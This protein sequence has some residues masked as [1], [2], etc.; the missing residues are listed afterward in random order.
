MLRRPRDMAVTIGLMSWRG[1]PMPQRTASSREL[2]QVSGMPGA[3][4]EEQHVDAAALGDARDLLVDLEVRIDAAGPRAQ[5]APA[6]VEMR[7]GNVERRDESAWALF[8]PHRVSSVVHAPSGMLDQERRYCVLSM[9]A[10]GRHLF[11]SLAHEFGE[12][13][14]RHRLDLVAVAVVA[15]LDIR[16]AQTP[17]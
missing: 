1:Q 15:F 13:L 2:S 6:A 7:V 4:A 14:R 8:P 16:R 5:H 3:V 12:R 11:I 9:P 17:R 10:S